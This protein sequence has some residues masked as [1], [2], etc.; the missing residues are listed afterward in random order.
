MFWDPGEEKLSE[1]LG[2]SLSTKSICAR[3]VNRLRKHLIDEKTISDKWL[4]INGRWSVI[5]SS[6]R[7]V[8]TGLGAARNPFASPLKLS[9]TMIPWPSSMLSAA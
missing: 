7:T 3:Y 8:G 9:L 4:V 5:V 6:F 2:S 1:F